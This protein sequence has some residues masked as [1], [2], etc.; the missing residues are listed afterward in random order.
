[1]RGR[2]SERPFLPMIITMCFVL[3]A[4]TDHA[5]PRRAFNQSAP[6]ISVQDLESSEEPVRVHFRK[7]AVQ[8]IGSTSNCGCDFPHA[9]F[10]GGGWP[11]ADYFAESEKENASSHR[12][13]MD[14]LV[15]LLRATQEDS[16]E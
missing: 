6:D 4:G 9:I 7:P 10:Q 11:E 12:F 2:F 13:N 3:C 8:N 1:M 14:S 16:A 5:I 15:A